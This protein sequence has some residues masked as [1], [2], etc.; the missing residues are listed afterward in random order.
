VPSQQAPFFVSQRFHSFQIR[1]VPLKTHF[2]LAMSRAAVSLHRQR[3]PQQ[4]EQLLAWYKIRD[5]L[6]G[7]YFAKQDVKKALELTAVCNHPDAVWLTKLF[8]GSDVNTPEQARQVFLDCENDARALCFAALLLWDEEKVRRA[9]DLGDSLAQA[10]MASATLG[11]EGFRWAEKSAL[12]GERDGFYCI[13]RWFEDG[14]DVERAKKNYLIAA[15]L[16]N[17]HAVITLSELLDETD[18][19]RCY[20]LGRA[21]INGNDGPFLNEMVVQTQKFYSGTGHADVVFAIGRALQGHIDDDKKTIFGNNWNCDSLIGPVN[22]AL[23]FYNFQL[24]SYRRAVDNWTLVGIRNGVV[25]DVRKMIGKM[26][27]DSRENA[28]F[29]VNLR[30]RL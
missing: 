19:K 11:E 5:M 8:A 20:W 1:N 7:H 18:P 30:R 12:Q 13:G 27:W 26:I 25:K 14:E 3:S 22:Q 6:F 10:W 29:K 23:H 4:L 2:F 24:Q 9:A 16:G 15:E 21:A 17:I 28:E